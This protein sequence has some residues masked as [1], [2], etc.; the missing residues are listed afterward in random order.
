MF[1]FDF[2][3]DDLDEDLGQL[4]I[5]TSH[6]AKE[7]KCSEYRVFSEISIPQLLD[8]LP[9]LISY[10]PLSVPLSSNQTITLARRDLFDARFQLI[11]EDDVKSEGDEPRML[12]TS[13]ALE[14]IEAPSDLVP[15]VYEGGL[16]TWECSLDLVSYL[17][18]LK[19][20]V[21]A[22]Q[23]KR[24]LEIGCGTAV[25]SL[26]ILCR[27]FSVPS[28]T[29]ARTSETQLHFQDYNDSVLELVTFP[30]V[31]LTWYMSDA[32]ASYRET[33]TKT[34]DDP[35]GDNDVTASSS[36][37]DCSTPGD[38]RITS[39]LKQAFLSSLAERNISLRFFSGSWDTFDVSNT[40]GKY[41]VVLTSETIYRTDSLLALINL[42]QAASGPSGSIADGSQLSLIPESGD[43]AYL[44]L[45]ASKILY[46]GV[47]GGVSE[48]VGIVE[49]SNVRDGV[50]RGKVETVWELSTGVGRKVMRV[51]WVT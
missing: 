41:D 48:F 24:V 31:L 40:G 37:P 27:L 9:A 3:I 25:P 23:G 10:S 49:G 33:E 45:V 20:P 39:E 50:K 46:F 22:I 32:A 7:A 34:E 36:I 29:A 42:M 12:S 17:D 5:P 6:Q 13:T 51:Q 18:G 35:V 8:R 30:N 19:F 2:D 38:L 21:E 47:G 14:F 15:G 28:S 4:S 26:Y 1:K 43:S 16:K 11:L 44:C